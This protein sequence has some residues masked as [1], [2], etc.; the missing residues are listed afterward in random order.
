MVI[1]DVSERIAAQQA[2]ED[3][4]SRHRQIV[5]LSPDGIVIHA[6]NRIVFANNAAQKMFAVRDEADL[7]GLDSLA[8]IPDDLKDLV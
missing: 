5:D 2:L 6:D 3:S 1:R 8:V 4:E 7:I